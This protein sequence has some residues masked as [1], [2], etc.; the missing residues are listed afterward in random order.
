MWAKALAILTGILEVIPIVNKWFTKTTS[1]TV[2]EERED[3]REDLDK[4]R[5]DGRPTWGK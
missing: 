3:V 5:E 1:E 2:N 4:F